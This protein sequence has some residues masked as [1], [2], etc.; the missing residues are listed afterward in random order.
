MPEASFRPLTGVRVLALE[1]A[2]S[3]PYCTFVLAELGAEVIKIERT[4]GGDVIRGWDELV[5]GLSSGFVWVNANKRSVTID[6][7]L[8]E[9]RALVEELALQ[10]DVFVENLAPG[11]ADRLGLSHAALMAANPRLI[12]CS[13]SGF[14]ADGPYG[15]VKSYD[16]TIQAESGILI[17]N[18]YPGMPA[19]VGLPVTDLIAGSNAVIGIQAALI[20]RDR[21]GVGRF[22]DVTMLDSA[23]LWLGYFPHYAWHAGTEPPLS[24]MRHQ[25]IC[26]YGPYLA[27]DDRYVCLAVADDRQ[28]QLFCRDVVECPEW[29]A[30]PRIATLAARRENRSFAEE[31]VEGAI[32]S[33][34]RAHWVERLA[35]SGI[36]YGVVRTMA[37]V[38]EHPQAIARRMFV[39]A[40][41][42]VGSVPMIRF[43]LA[44]ADLARTLP[45][46]GGDT[47]A[48]LSSLGVD[49]CRA[50]SLRE[51]RVI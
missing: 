22:L 6:V 20:E 4:D 12:Y 2:V 43:P 45:A 7:A 46:L 29:I 34:P 9:G 13:L 49:R 38:V 36:P 40:D 39:A 28:W 32:A 3:M 23:L 16:L 33:R 47:D 44:D 35:T 5:H 17:S 19:K 48:V 50:A 1:Q 21:T 30:D 51:R 11:A 14:G 8:P 31:L 27:A 18:G 10:I 41:S 15:G 24:G 25:Y 37:E 26:P 42:P